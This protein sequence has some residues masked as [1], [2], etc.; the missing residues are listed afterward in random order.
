MTTLSNRP[1]TALLVIDVQNGV[2]G[3]ARAVLR[4]WPTSRNSSSEPAEKRYPSCGCSTTTTDT[5]GLRGGHIVAELE[6]DGGEPRVEKNYFDSFEETRSRTSSPTF[7][8]AG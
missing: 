5:Q 3:A 8:W 4:S 6:P 2:I 7:R 1:N